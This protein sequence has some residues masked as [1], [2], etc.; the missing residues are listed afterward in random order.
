MD[1]NWESGLRKSIKLVLGVAGVALVG[2]FIYFLI[3]N[4]VLM[5][6]IEGLG[7]KK[8]R[9]FTQKVAQEREIVRREFEE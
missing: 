7:G 2:V 9:E 3:I 5:M 6:E 1:I 4:L 8:E